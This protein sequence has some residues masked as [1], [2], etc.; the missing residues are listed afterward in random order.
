M[1]KLLIN[2]LVL[3]SLFGV[4][5]SPS[6]EAYTTKDVGSRDELANGLSAFS[7]EDEYL[8]WLLPDVNS[9]DYKNR[10]AVKDRQMDLLRKKQMMSV[11]TTEYEHIINIPGYLQENSYYCVPAACQNIIYAV[12]GVNI[13]QDTLASAMG[14]KCPEGTHSSAAAAELRRRTGANY[15]VGLISNRQFFPQLKADINDGFPII[16]FVWY[17]WYDGYHTHVPHA[18]V[19]NGYDTYYN[20]TYCFDVAGKYGTGKQATS[21][22]SQAELNSAL[23]C[24]I[25]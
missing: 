17:D 6:M 16:F 15:E 9:A 18:I 25:Y 21:W 11:R 22:K 4:L 12:K 2:L 19:G 13:D 10:M 3:F 8:K 23:I 14:T 1:K 5:T 24:Y 20:T 7:S